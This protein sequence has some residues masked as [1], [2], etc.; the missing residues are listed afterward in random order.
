MNYL[1]S[2]EMAKKWNISSRRIALL[3]SEG[4]IDGAIK[5]G[6]TWLI[7]SEACKPMDARKVEGQSNM[8]TKKEENKT[9]AMNDIVDYAT[10]KI[11]HNN[12]EEAYRQEFEHILIDD[13]GYPKENIDI[14]VVIQRGAARNA[15]EADIVVYR[16]NIHKQDNAYIV[17]EIETPK[18]TYDLQAMS[19]VTATTAPYA[20]WYAG[21]EKNSKGPFYHYRDMAVDPIDFMLIPTL[22][23]YGETQETIGKYRKSDLKPA[24]ALKLTFE[25][26]YYHLYGTGPIKREENIAVEIIKLLFC[27]IID[28]LAPEDLC[29][30]RATPSEQSTKEGRKI[31]RDRI[32]KLYEKLLHDPDYGEMFKGESLEYDADS[33]AYIVS[34]LQGISLTDEETNTDALGDAYEVLL[35]STLKGESGQ[36]FTPR[37]IV[38]FAIAIINPRYEKNEYILD[39]ACGS[40]GFLSVALEMIRKQINKLYS[41]RGYSKEKKR[42]LLRDYA[43][44]Y[45]YGCDIDPLLYRI[46]K[47]YMAIMG[48]GKGNIFKLDSLDVYDKLDPIF[49]NSVKQGNIDIITTNPPFGTQIK[50]TRKDVLE[51]YDLGH[52]IVDGE[53]TNELLD[54]QDPDKL[55][56]ERDISYLKEAFVDDNGIEHDGGRMVIVLPKQNLSGANEESVEFRKWLLKRVQITAIVDLPREAFQPH[57]GTKTSLVFVKKVRKLSDDYPI[58]MAVSESVGHDRRGLPLYKK[59]ANGTDLVDDNNNKVIWNDLPDIL[60]RYKEYEKMGVLNKEVNNGP[61]CFIINAKDIL[62]D[63]TRRIDAWYWDPNKNNIAKKIEE[64]VGTEIKEIVRLGDLVIDHGIFYPGRHKRNYVAPNEN[65]VPFYSGTQILQVRPFDIKYQPKDYNPARKHFVEKDWI[66]ITRSGSTG[67]VVMVTDSMAGS[68]VTE[69]VIR[70]ICDKNIIDPYYVYAYLATEDIGKVL[71]EKGIYASVVDHITPEFVATIP[72]PR[73][74]PEKEKEIAD[75]VRNAEEMRD[76]ANREFAEERDLLESIMFDNMKE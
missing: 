10:G 39:T 19:Y 73:L 30:F 2:N 49:R 61:S 64:S 8:D 25:R 12:P 66:L 28:E 23:R 22:P 13:L 11:V 57:T 51:T 1:T 67:R 17:I 59:D 4:R 7:P 27:K 48:E 42:S 46:S 52:K 70:V 37:E 3:C 71:L 20:V 18:K 69:H 54:G 50:D 6:K 32:Q 58:F 34:I 53:P 31:I 33:I 15:E 35:P 76:K 74:A 72:V 26:M 38:R 5:R 41:S 40:A 62:S 55:F 9:V 44:K 75:K 36:F 68:M 63:P 29:E 47:S 24:K 14:E 65:S 60:A 56:V 21:M 16:N 45:V 43:S